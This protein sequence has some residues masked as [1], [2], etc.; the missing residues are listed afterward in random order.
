M[1]WLLL[2]CLIACKPT[3]DEAEPPPPVPQ[4]YAVLP[5]DISDQLGTVGFVLALDLEA[6]EVGK[7]E[8]LWKQVPKCVDDIAHT[9]K[10]V[11]V[12]RGATDWQGYVT[13][14]NGPSLRACIEGFGPTLGASVTAAGSDYQ[15]DVAGTTAVLHT[16]GTFTTITQGSNTPHAGEAPA[17]ITDLLSRVPKSAHGLFVAGGFPEYKVKN[18]VAYLE[19]DPSTWK[20]TVFADGSQADMAMP[21]LQSLVTGFKAALKAKG[22]VASDD[23]F[24]IEATP[25]AGKLVMTVPISA[26]A[27]AR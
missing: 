12:T 4:K 8:L 7:L 22:V 1:R 16:A 5:D 11:A 26:L 2:L 25:M 18:V 13:G 9:A 23:W 21:W 14:V 20:F 17:V 3:K 15:V 19:T 27:G 6:M 10:I 24:K